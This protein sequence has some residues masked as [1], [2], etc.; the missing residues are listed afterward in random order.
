MMSIMFYNMH[1]LFAIIWRMLMETGRGIYM[2][3]ILQNSKL[4]TAK[5][6]PKMDNSQKMGQSAWSERLQQYLLPSDPVKHSAL[7]GQEKSPNVE[8]VWQ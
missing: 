3:S 2:P 5:G 8:L 1:V 6:F 7:R 4:S